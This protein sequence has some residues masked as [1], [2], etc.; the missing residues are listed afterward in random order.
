MQNSIFVT[1]LQ[2]KVLYF[3]NK[4]VYPC[5]Q[6]LCPASF[7][8]FSPMSLGMERVLVILVLVL[9]IIILIVAVLFLLTLQTSVI[10]ITT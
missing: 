1:P 8:L 5:L 10:I 3:N 2:H 6:M 9:I 4:S 7:C